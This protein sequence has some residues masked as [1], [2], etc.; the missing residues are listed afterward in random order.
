M[1]CAALGFHTNVIYIKNL[2]KKNTFSYQNCLLEG[3][4]NVLLSTVT[5]YSQKAGAVR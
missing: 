4:K 2:E 1:K 5:E 3:Q